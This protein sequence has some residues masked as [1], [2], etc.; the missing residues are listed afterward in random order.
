MTLMLSNPAIRP[1]PCPE[2]ERKC[3]GYVWGR[4]CSIGVPPMHAVCRVLVRCSDGS[5]RDDLLVFVGSVW[6]RGDLR[7]STS[8]VVEW[9]VRGQK[10]VK[11]GRRK[12]RR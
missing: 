11:A 3:A 2:F 5:L 1:M 7:V 8:D 10:K 4:S 6:C 12:G 9:S